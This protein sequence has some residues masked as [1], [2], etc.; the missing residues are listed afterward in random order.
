MGVLSSYQCNP[1]SC[2]VY[3]DGVGYSS[4]G[5][6]ITGKFV[7][8]T[9]PSTYWYRST[10]SALASLGCKLI[11]IDSMAKSTFD[12]IEGDGILANTKGIQSTPLLS[13][14][15]ERYLSDEYLIRKP[16]TNVVPCQ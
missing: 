9:N 4:S 6:A 14:T 8:S 16:N 7:R 13:I 2:V 11:S 1:T 5:I 15:Y 12:P 3:A 10:A